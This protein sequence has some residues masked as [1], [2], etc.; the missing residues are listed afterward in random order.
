M[1]SASFVLLSQEQ[2]LRR[3]LDVVAN[4]MAN[5]STV[6]FKRE[7]PQFHEFVEQMPDA[8]VPDARNTSYVLDYGTVHDTTPGSFQPTGNPL[9]V[10]IEGNGYLTVEGENGQSLYTRAGSLKVSS[11][12]ELVTPA[13]LR[14][15]GEGEQPI[16]VPLDQAAALAIAADGSITGPAGQLG[17]LAITRFGNEGSVKPLGNNLFS[18][19]GGEPV[20]AAEIRV[21][22]GGL[23]SSNVQPIAETTTMIEVLRAYQTSQKLSESMN[24]LR[25]RAID[26]LGRAG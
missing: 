23:E 21:R 2:A 26:R 5:A 16:R 24:D 11:E 1:D 6:G 22:A 3:R 20:P 9:D 14:V 10:M 19:Q 12:G 7:Q 13:G 8:E 17:R 4:N 15:L 18:G 25:Q